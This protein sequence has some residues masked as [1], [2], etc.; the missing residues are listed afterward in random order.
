MNRR[1]EPRIPSKGEVTLLTH[2]QIHIRGNIQEV[3]VGGLSVDAEVEIA[4]GTHIQIDCHD[5]YATGI[6]R[7]CGACGSAFRLGVELRPPD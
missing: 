7:H 3:S 2:D 1:K 4:P 6:V 5:F